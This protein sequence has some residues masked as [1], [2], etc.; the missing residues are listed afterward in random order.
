MILKSTKLYCQYSQTSLATKATSF[1]SQEQPLMGILKSL[2]CLLGSHMTL[3]ATF[4]LKTYLWL[5]KST[6]IQDIYIVYYIY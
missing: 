5:W 1:D 6:H 2:I 4:L 3:L